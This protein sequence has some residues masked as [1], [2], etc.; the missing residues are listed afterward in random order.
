MLGIMFLLLAAAEGIK[1]RVADVLLV[2]GQVPLFYFLIHLF[3][4]H[5]L[6]LLMLFLQGF[7]WAEIP[8]GTFSL[9]RPKAVSGVGLWGTYL[10]WILVVISLYPLCKWYGRYKSTHREQKWLRYL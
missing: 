10:T 7:S 9:G 3:L 8:I 1:N 2:Y 6:M 5:A 4:I